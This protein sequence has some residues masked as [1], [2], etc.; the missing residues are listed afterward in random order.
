MVESRLRM[1]R[2][3]AVGD[4]RRREEIERAQGTEREEEIL[5]HGAPIILK[6]V[7]TYIEMTLWVLD[8]R[9]G[10]LCLRQAGSAAGWQLLPPKLLPIPNQVDLEKKFVSIPANVYGEAFSPVSVSITPRLEH[11]NWIPF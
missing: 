9:I 8:T 3:V 11:W 7:A 10:Q 6:Q 2:P 4:C 1:W 5:A